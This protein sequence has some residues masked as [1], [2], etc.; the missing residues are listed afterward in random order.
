MELTDVIS[1]KPSVSSEWSIRGTVEKPRLFNRVTM[2]TI[3]LG[4]MEI[5]GYIKLCNGLRTLSDISSITGESINIVYEF[6]KK[7]VDER[8]ILYDGE[9]REIDIHLGEKEPWLKEVHIDITSACN[10]RCR[11][12]FWGEKIGNCVTVPFEKWRKLIHDISE[13]GVGKVILSGGEFFTS[14]DAS[15]FVYEIVRNKLA[16]AAIFTNGTIWDSN[17]ERILDFIVANNLTTTFYVSLDGRND[18]EH[19][20]IRGKGNYDK[21]MLFVRKLIEYRTYKKAKYSVVINSLIHKRNCDDLIGWYNQ[22]EE[23]G[24]DRWRFT[25]GR[26]AGGLKE[27]QLEIQVRMND[28]YEEYI[29][30][31]KYVS[32]L[33]EMNKLHM[34]I[35]IE[36]FFS[37]YMLKEKQMFIFS[38]DLTIC[39]YKRNGCSIDPLGNMQICTSWQR[40]KFGNVFENNIEQLWSS[41]D[42]QKIKGMKISEIE[43]CRDC[44]YLKYCGGGCRVEAPSLFQKDEYI[45]DNYKFFSLKIIPLLRKMGLR[46]TV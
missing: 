18:E 13:A 30:L 26:I 36:S 39:D 42:M 8:V 20:F 21:T 5:V 3:I 4:N 28:I 22:L 11:H 35:N 24:V 16:L 32:N 23:I 15:E 40:D 29:K 17:V 38:E 19:G 9:E 7:F 46:E 33:Y 25:T 41:S 31:I 1:L 14:I 34:D 2:D 12:C 37:S 45:C 27:N 44:E 43:E 10:L 6:Y